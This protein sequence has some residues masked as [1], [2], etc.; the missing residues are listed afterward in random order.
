MTYLPIKN[1]F[2]LSYYEF[3]HEMLVCALPHCP[4]HFLL[5][6]EA[7]KILQ[8]FSSITWLKRPNMRDETF[9]A[10]LIVLTH[11]QD[12]DEKELKASFYFRQIVK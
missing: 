9:K 7:L 6:S 2:Y 11:V 3:F 1:Y 10:H 8:H 12:D 5:F 4:K